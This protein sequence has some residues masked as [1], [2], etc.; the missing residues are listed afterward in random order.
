MDSEPDGSITPG[1]F[2]GFD[3]VED[4]IEEG[5]PPEDASADPGGPSSAV[6]V[7]LLAS[8]T[9]GLAILALLGIAHPH[10]TIREVKSHLTN[11][12]LSRRH[13]Q[14]SVWHHPLDI[15]NFGGSFG[16]KLFSLPDFLSLRCLR[17]RKPRRGTPW[18]A[19][20]PNPTFIPRKQW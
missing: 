2:V 1:M 10:L 9:I 6:V 7:L 17:H 18:F 11:P 5:E 15:L 12:S 20:S 4:Q 13:R 16:E 14:P 8:V 19:N 3:P